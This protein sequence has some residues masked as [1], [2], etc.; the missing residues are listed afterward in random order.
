MLIY[1]E[2]FLNISLDVGSILIFIAFLVS[3]ILAFPVGKLVDNLGRKKVVIFSVVFESVSL[4]LFAISR[5]FV[6]VAITASMWL[7]GYVAW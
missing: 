5:E 3:I 1:I 7:F 2:H 6:F 4:L